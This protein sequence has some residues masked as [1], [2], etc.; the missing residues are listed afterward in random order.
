M[1]LFST[2]QTLTMP[3]NY[4][5]KISDIKR[6]ILYRLLL[7]QNTKQY[8]KFPFNE[9]SYVLGSKTFNENERGQIL[10]NEKPLND[11]GVEELVI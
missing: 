10:E 1:Y 3:V 6:D 4:N 7:V 8:L 11:Y 2:E 5:N 9:D